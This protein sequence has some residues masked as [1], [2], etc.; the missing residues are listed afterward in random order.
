MYTFQLFVHLI[1]SLIILFADAILETYPTKK[2]IEFEEAVS[3]WFRFAKHRGN[4]QTEKE[5][6]KLECVIRSCL[7]LI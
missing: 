5:R 7:T 6:K 3:D 1:V 2:E 4:R